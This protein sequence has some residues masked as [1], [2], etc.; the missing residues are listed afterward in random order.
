MSLTPLLDLQIYAWISRYL[1]GA[2]SL[3][4][5]E[6]WFV[7]ATWEVERTGL[8]PA[9]ELATPI[10]TALVELSVGEI[11]EADF[12]S[13]LSSLE[14]QR[15]ERIRMVEA[16]VAAHGQPRNETHAFDFTPAA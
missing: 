12:R 3:D 4:E 6:D 16:F 10:R 8:L 14:S 11:D 9:I 15:V 5:F 1:S 7:P 2:A 13:L